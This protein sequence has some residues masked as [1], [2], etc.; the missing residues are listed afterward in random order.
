MAY[1]ASSSVPV[2]A[3]AVGYNTETFGPAVTLG[4]QLAT[5]GP[6]PPM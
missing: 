6:T 5:G 1:T 2:A 4:K 3:A